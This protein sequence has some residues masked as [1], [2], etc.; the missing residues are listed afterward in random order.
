MN[1]EAP[2]RLGPGGEQ[3][4]AETATLSTSGFGAIFGALVFIPIILLLFF[5]LGAGY[6]SYQK[7]GSMLWA[8][9]DF[10]FAYFY[11]PYYSFFL[12]GS[13]MEP[14]PVNTM[15]GGFKKLF[16]GRRR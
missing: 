14:T 8:I 13:S 12:S 16:G 4:P 11:Y 6:L 7:Y 3:K 15:L 5:H 10:I 1:A 2:P 9:V